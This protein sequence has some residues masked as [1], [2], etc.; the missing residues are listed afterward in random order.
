MAQIL[1]ASRNQGKVNE[2]AEMMQDLNVAWLGLADIGVDMDVV[3]TGV[4][5]A[6]NA[7]LK[8]RIYARA[9]G[10]LSLADDSGLEVDALQGAP[11]VYTA[12]YGGAGL[13][14]EARYRLVLQQLASVPA[15]QR[16]ARFRCVLALAAPDGRLLTTAE[17]VCEGMIAAAPAGA[18]GFGYDP[19]FYLPDRGKTMAQLEAAE[20]HQISHRG[21]AM[22]QL[23]PRLRQ[24][25]REWM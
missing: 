3:E 8:A 5:F 21:R 6:E 7:V 9:S 14:P 10:L 11:G 17:G 12:R 13:T 23:E 22:R 20:K 18:G 15:A 4:T 19:I 24:I 2:F 1:V 16:A 25:L